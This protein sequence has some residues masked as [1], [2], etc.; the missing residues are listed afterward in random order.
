MRGGTEKS[1]S[2]KERL[3]EQGVR[4]KGGAL[5][6]SEVQLHAIPSH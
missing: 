5:S 2:A 6:T 3:V 1:K 4:D